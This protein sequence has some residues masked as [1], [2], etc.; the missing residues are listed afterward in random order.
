MTARSDTVIPQVVI[1]VLVCVGLGME[2]VRDGNPRTDKHSFWITLLSD[3][4]VLALLWWGGFF[5]PLFGS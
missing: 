1:L 2:L 5:N 4:I 3:T